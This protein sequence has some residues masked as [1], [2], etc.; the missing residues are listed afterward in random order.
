[1]LNKVLSV[2]A[3]SGADG[4]FADTEK[5]LVLT[6]NKFLVGFDHGIDFSNKHFVAWFIG[7]PA[8]FLIL[9]NLFRS[10]GWWAFTLK[11][12]TTRASDDLAFEIVA[13]SCCLYLAVAGIIGRF[14][15]FGAN[16]YDELEEDPFYAGSD[17]VKN[18]LSK[19]FCSTILV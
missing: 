16:N 19:S 8:S 7:V 13:G 2:I 15:L 4:R 10:Q 5:Q 6:N 17:F 18:H 11:G 3:K 1:M 9:A 14:G 12:T